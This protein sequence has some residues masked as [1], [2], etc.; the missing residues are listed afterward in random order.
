V[1]LGTVTPACALDVVGGIKT[2]RTTVTLPAATDGNIFSGTYTPTLTNTTNIAASTAYVTGYFRVGNM[3][4]V[5]G[6]VNI[7]PTAASTAS[8]LRISLP[9]ASNFANNQ[10]LGGVGAIAT[11]VA[12]VSSGGIL[13]DATNDEARFLFTSGGT[14]ARDYYFTFSY[15]V[16]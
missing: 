10:N 9:I 11:G 2:S 3:V 8:E 5:A 4:T 13:A 14:A 7:D 16:L 6:R 1:G 15:Q 12:E